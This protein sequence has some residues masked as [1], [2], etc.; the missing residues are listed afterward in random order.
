MARNDLL[1]MTESTTMEIP[2]LA[3]CDG[4][5]A[6]LLVAVCDAVNDGDLIAEVE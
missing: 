2:G 6:R 4:V 5:L 3:P 1:V